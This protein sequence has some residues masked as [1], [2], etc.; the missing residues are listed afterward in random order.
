MKQFTKWIFIIAILGFILVLSYKLIFINK[1]IEG[2]A[3][4]T[5]DAGHMKNVNQLR[6][7]RNNARFPDCSQPII[8]FD[9]NLPKGR[10]PQTERWWFNVSN[11]NVA[12]LLSNY[13]SC[14]QGKMNP[15]YNDLNTKLNAVEQ[16]ISNS[17][18]NTFYSGVDAEVKSIKATADA[19]GF[20]DA[21]NNNQGKGDAF[22]PA[23]A[24][25]DNAINYVS[26]RNTE[27]SNEIKP[28]LDNMINT[29]NV[30]AVTDPN[31]RDDIYAFITKT[32][33]TDVPKLKNDAWLAKTN[34]SQVSSTIDAA[35]KRCADLNLISD[36]CGNIS[37][38]HKSC[39]VAK[40]KA[41]DIG[42]TIDNGID[43]K[44]M[45]NYIQDLIDG[46]DVSIQDSKKSF[47][48]LKKSY[49]TPYDEANEIAITADAYCKSQSQKYDNWQIQLDEVEQKPCKQEPNIQLPGSTDINNSALKNAAAI[50]DVLSSLEARLEIIKGNLKQ[51]ELQIG[52]TTLYELIIDSTGE[53]TFDYSLPGTQPV[54][55]IV[56]SKP[57]KINFI[58]PMG[59]NGKVGPAGPQGPDFTVTSYG[60]RG[61]RGEQSR[62]SGLPEQWNQ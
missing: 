43:R 21:E 22:M 37:K 60:P 44:N 3:D 46:S 23:F 34:Y 30:T 24:I 41:D 54:V 55:S 18:L 5:A 61:P 52:N 17:T 26:L 57:Q 40:K 51:N 8:T 31:M 53:Q 20:S 50:Q 62:Y 12:N 47:W 35:Q 39:E 4:D 56:G 27:N 6:A 10:G 32:V 38:F 15:A 16:S 9:N 13:Y 11:G 29:C 59:L 49:N 33:E 14:V 19:K 48:D 58:L 42:D 2:G 1:I 45:V 28:K 25:V 7:A 36:L